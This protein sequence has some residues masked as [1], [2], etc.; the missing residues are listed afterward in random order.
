M[1][2]VIY[3]WYHEDAEIEEYAPNLKEW[4]I[5]TAQEDDFEC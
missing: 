2:D 1:G 4:I 3:L 5:T